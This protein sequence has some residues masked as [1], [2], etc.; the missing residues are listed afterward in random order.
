MHDVDV[1]LPCP[2]SLIRF[3]DIQLLT[4]QLSCRL[5]IERATY[6]YANP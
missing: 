2:R 3:G 5:L 1:T 6:M 4:H